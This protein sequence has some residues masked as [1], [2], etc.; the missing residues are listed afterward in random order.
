MQRSHSVGTG[1]SNYTE[2]GGRGDDEGRRVMRSHEVP[3]MFGPMS[4]QGI[5]SSL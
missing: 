2:H 1:L 5:N 4:P 3:M